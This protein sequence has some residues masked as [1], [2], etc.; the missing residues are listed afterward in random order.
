MYPWRKQPICLY[1]IEPI[2]FWVQ[3]TRRSMESAQQSPNERN[4]TLTKCARSS[5]RLLVGKSQLSSNRKNISINQNYLVDRE[6][7]RYL[8]LTINPLVRLGKWSLNGC[9]QGS[10]P[11]AVLLPLWPHLRQMEK[12]RQSEETSLFIQFNSEIVNDSSDSNTKTL[13]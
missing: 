8:L 5:G 2:R 9:Q 3:C 13:Y 4:G 10:W 1:L 12:W 6:L 11:G 7:L